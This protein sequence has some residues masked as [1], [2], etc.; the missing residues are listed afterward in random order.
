MSIKIE[1]D[2]A[3]LDRRGSLALMAFLREF[4]RGYDPLP[5]AEPPEDGED[6]AP[7]G[8]AARWM[9]NA[10]KESGLIAAPEPTT[11]SAEQ[12]FAVAPAENVTV[13][14]AAGGS[15]GP[16]RPVEVDKSGIPWNPE[17]HSTPAKINADGLWRRKR[18]VDPSAV[19]AGPAGAPPTPVAPPA[20]P[21]PVAPVPTPP[22]P[23]PAPVAP[24]APPAPVVAV[25]EVP[26]GSV[27]FTEMMTLNQQ[28]A[29]A[30]KV[31]GTDIMRFATELGGDL[32]MAMS[33]PDFCARLYA[34]LLQAQAA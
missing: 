1:F 33:N 24:P 13:L 11:V 20:P 34:R 22:A 14:T 9:E 5:A 17:Y 8:P 6:P 31:A 29:Q 2:T 18:G 25:P 15:G 19:P 10:L 7:D 21:T 23:A 27:S 16:A 12:A 3:A 28:L 26:A 4:S 30:G 32:G